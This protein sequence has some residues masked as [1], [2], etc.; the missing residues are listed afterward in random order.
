MIC[1]PKWGIGCSV[2][3]HWCWGLESKS[4][5]LSCYNAAMAA[6]DQKARWFYPTPDRLVVPLLVLECLLW[7]SNWLGWWHKGYAVLVTIAVVGVFLLLMLIWFVLALVFR[8][9]FQ[10][11][12]RTLLVLVVVVAVPFSWLAAEM[13]KAREQKAVAEAMGKMGPDVVFYDDEVE[14]DGELGALSFG[15]LYYYFTGR[16]RS[17]LVAEPSEPQWLRDWLGEDFFRSLLAIEVQGDQAKTITVNDLRCVVALPSLKRLGLDDAEELSDGDFA[18]LSRNRNLE[19]LFLRRTQ[20]TDQG[21]RELSSLT[22]LRYLSLAK[23]KITDEGLVYLK[24]LTKLTMLELSD[25]DISDEGLKHLQ[26]LNS[27]QYLYLD[28]TKVT[29]KGVKELQAALPNCAILLCGPGVV[30]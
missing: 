21:L 10:F 14:P 1:Y 4:Q 5:A 29:K 6:A 20:V 27:L 2:A 26:G 22:N 9:R 7:L 24:R 28:G 11:S 13:K 23:T 25:T 18:F 3:E 15:D 12:L 19:R 8:R 16:E 30:G 17:H